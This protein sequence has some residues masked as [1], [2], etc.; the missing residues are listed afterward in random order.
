L[1]TVREPSA[2]VLAAV[3]LVALVGFTVL[4]LRARRLHHRRPGEAG[5]RPVPTDLAAFDA[6]KDRRSVRSQVSDGHSIYVS[7][8]DGAA[9]QGTTSR[10]ITAPC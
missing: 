10:D 3:L 9:V 4:L 2:L 8:A 6:F 7:A 1:S 5:R